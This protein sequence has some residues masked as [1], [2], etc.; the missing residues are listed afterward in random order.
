MKC[1]TSSRY[2]RRVRALFCFCSQI[3]SSGMSASWSSVETWL[4]PVVIGTSKLVS[5][6]IMSADPLVFALRT[7]I[8]ARDKNRIIT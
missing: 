4:R 7:T 5:S 3:V 8:L 2:A 6:S 1:W